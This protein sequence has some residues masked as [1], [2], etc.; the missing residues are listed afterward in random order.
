M[1]SSNEAPK[2]YLNKFSPRPY[3]LP[4]CDALEN[5]RYR[6]IIA[7]WPRRAGKD[8]TAFNLCVRQCLRRVGTIFYIFPTFS[9]GRRILWDA[10][11]NDGTRILDY[12]PEEL[13]ESR[14][15]QQ[16]RIRFKNGSVI[17]VIGSDN[18]DNTL[19][20]VNAMGMVFSEYA[21][22]DPQAY[23]FAR[24]IL[25]ANDGW[26]LFISTPRGKNHLYDMY[27]MALKYPNEWFA[28][29]LTVEDT[30][31]VSLEEIQ[32]EIDSG[33]MSQDLAQQEW[34]CS[35]TM[36]V[37]GSYYAA[38]LDK[39]R[40]SGQIGMVPWDPSHKVCTAWDIG[41][42][43]N[44]SIVFFQ[45]VGLTIRVIDFYEK[46][47]EGLEHYVKV[48]NDKP[49]Q[50][51]KHIA[52]HDI[53]VTEW[54]SGMTRIEKAKQLGITFTLSNNVSIDDGIESV[55]SSFSKIWIDESRCK[56]LIKALEN[57]RQEWDP[58]RQVYKNN[59]LHDKWSHA[60][61]A[62]RYLCVSLKKVMTTS[63][64]EDIERR[65]RE[66]VY[67]EDSSFPKFFR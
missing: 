54:G 19:V 61:D 10:I 66:A 25:A 44:T 33:E 50:Y 12:I 18:Y 46:S 27:T 45:V 28:Q 11:Q 26:A 53:A 40:I 22:T 9:S 57:Y 2:I 47:K 55:R 34:F 56:H 42:R 52:P 6:R 31:H 7:I 32:K 13:V 51:H 17:Q 20:G 36:G 39:M 24:P 29:K 4:V 16:M 64:P 60:A 23:Q 58:K 21:L 30:G 43:D 3:Q 38:Y 63:S 59:P 41:H 65:Y 15:E 49:Y 1:E 14:N 67:G 8:I 48:I 35:F 37:Q 5:K 62:F